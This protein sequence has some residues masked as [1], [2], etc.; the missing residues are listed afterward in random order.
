MDMMNM[1]DMVGALA[2]MNEEKRKTMMSERLE[3]FANLSEGERRD[4]MKQMMGAV[5]KLGESDK[6]KLIKS[7]TIIL[8]EMSDTDRKKL[9]GAHM[10]IMKGMGQDKMMGEMKI[11]QSIMPELSQ[12][13]QKILEGMM[14]MMP[15]PSMGMGGGGMSMGAS[16]SGTGNWGL[17]CTWITALLGL[18]V[19]LSPFI[20]GHQTNAAPLWNDVILGVG[21][22]ILAG[23]VAIVKAD[24]RFGSWPLG[25]MWISALAGIWLILAPFILQYQEVSTALGGDIILGIGVTVLAGAVAIGKP[26]LG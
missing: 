13:H 19:F 9:M 20:L 12:E 17:T 16:G 11:I 7:R 4:S 8:C 22:V 6:R 2:S 25:F 23:I 26:S 1:E 3:M 21:I 10:E 15:M 5:G 24:L 18:A 14:K